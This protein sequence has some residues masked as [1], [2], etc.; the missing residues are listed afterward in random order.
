MLVRKQWSILT[1]L[2]LVENLL[3]LSLVFSFSASLKSFF[4]PRRYSGNRLTVIEHCHSSGRH[5][6]YKI[7]Y[8]QLRYL[9]NVSYRSILAFRGI[10]KSATYC[11][12]L[13]ETAG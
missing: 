13:L 8:A 12:R 1:S 6:P 5:M 10:Y 4:L 2:T 7:L 11:H 9:E 3:G